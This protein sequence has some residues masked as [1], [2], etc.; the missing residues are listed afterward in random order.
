MNKSKKYILDTIRDH[1]ECYVGWSMT[2]GQRSKNAMYDLIDEGKIK[3]VDK[4]FFEKN[5]R[6]SC[7]VK[8]A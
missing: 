6:T 4:Q 3:I 2:Y 5:W 7:V 1:G 8:A